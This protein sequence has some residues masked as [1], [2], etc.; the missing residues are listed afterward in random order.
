MMKALEYLTNQLKMEKFKFFFI[1][2]LFSITAQAELPN[3][4]DSVFIEILNMKLEHPTIVMSQAIVESGH[5]Q[6]GLFFRNN[7]LFGMK[8]SGQRA[9]VTN[10]MKDGYKYYSHWKESVYD[11]ALLQMSYYKGLTREEYF[12][13]LSRS[14][15]SAEKYI[16]TIKKVEKNLDKYLTEHSLVL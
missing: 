15:A 4:L 8:Q 14:Y 10:K 1:L 6:S 9:T 5:M 7:N 2:L 11:Y 12:A 13:K 16:E 3:Q